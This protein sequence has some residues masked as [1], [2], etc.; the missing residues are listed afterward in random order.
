[1]E[2]QDIANKSRYYTIAALIERLT[3]RMAYEDPSLQP[4]A[5]YLRLATNWGSVGRVTLWRPEVFSE[6]VQK[7]LSS[8]GCIDSFWSEWNSYY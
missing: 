7:K 8:Q 2:L 6:D 4:F 3:T 1:M 5:E